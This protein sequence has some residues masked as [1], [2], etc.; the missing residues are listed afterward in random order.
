MTFAVLRALHG[1]IGEAIDDIERVF[2]VEADDSRGYTPTSDGTINTN[3]PSSAS[4]RYSLPSNEN[5]AVPSL[6]FPSLDTP[7]DPTSP[8]ERFLASGDHPE[9]G[10]AISRIVA[11]CGQLSMSVRE[12]FLSLCD[13]SMGYHLPSCLRF[14]EAT[15]TV[16]ILREAGTGGLHVK[17]IAKM[18]GTDETKLG[19]FDLLYCASQVSSLVCFPSYSLPEILVY[20]KTR[21][22]LAMMF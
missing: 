16:E 10:A 12:P 21:I 4:S 7:Y 13:G 17:E 18:N 11:A 8:A 5:P 22:F 14:L 9:L 6:D 3:S 15:H 2:A 20:E 1:I 19:E